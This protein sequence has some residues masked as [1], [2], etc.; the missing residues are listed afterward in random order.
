MSFIKMV[1]LVDSKQQLM[2]IERDA[3]NVTKSDLQAIVASSGHDMKS[4]ITSLLLAIESVVSTLQDDLASQSQSNNET[5]SRRQALGTCVDAFGTIMHLNMIV[6]RSVDYCKILANLSLTPSP[7][8][9]HVKDCIEQVINA[10]AA[11]AGMAVILTTVAPDVPTYLLTDA[12]WLQVRDD[13]SDSVHLHTCTCV[14]RSIVVDKSCQQHQVTLN[15][16]N[17]LSS[18]VSFSCCYAI[19]YHAHQ[20]NLLCMVGNACKYSQRQRVDGSDRGIT[21][22][23][24][25]VLVGGRKLVEFSV[26]DA[27]PHR[28]TPV[29]LQALYNRPVTFKREI[30]G[31]MG[32]GM[33]CLAARVQALGG[34]C[35]ARLRTDGAAGTVVWFR[36]PWKEGRGGEG[37]NASASGFVSTAGQRGSLGAAVGPVVLLMSRF[38]SV[39][40]LIRRVSSGHV[41]GEGRGDAP[42]RR[43]RRGVGKVEGERGEVD[44]MQREGGRE[45]GTGRGREKSERGRGRDREREKDESGDRA[46]GK[47]EDE[48]RPATTP[49]PALLPAPTSDRPLP[50]S[51]TPNAS[52][53]APA[54]GSTP[55]SLPSTARAPLAVSTLDLVPEHGPLHRLDIPSFSAQ[56]SVVQF[57]P[58]HTHQPL[59]GLTILVVD[60]APTI[61]KMVVRMLT[62]AG[63]TVD[64]AKDGR[65][66]LEVF[67]AAQ[68][69]FDMVVTDI[70]VP[71][72]GHACAYVYTSC[73]DARTYAHMYDIC[74]VL[75]PPSHFICL[76]LIAPFPF[77][78]S[79]FPSL[80]LSSS[81]ST[82][83]CL[84]WT[85]GGC[86]RPSA[87]WN[88]RAPMRPTATS[89]GPVP[90]LI[91]PLPRAAAL[92]RALALALAAVRVPA[93][94]P[95]AVW[96]S[97]RL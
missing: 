38:G 44:D 30:V 8:S 19:C 72:S 52:I 50:V 14:L 65:E 1:L 36:V 22:T 64:F 45:R 24:F 47:G 29:E 60:D 5:S 28:F 27:S 31:G 54:P 79:T 57:A 69:A 91:L 53:R 81:P 86:V 46:E 3:A 15:H 43:A 35:G 33:C 76:R 40:K 92:A 41:R 10:S 55:G 6:N 16:L 84:A 89:T 87:R 63:A 97:G 62:A 93:P 85:G 96:A 37:A 7:R 77:L 59:Q 82:S 39:S 51:L 42:Q 67:K 11:D 48:E 18:F 83:R 71:A 78:L 94:G 74:C 49:V 32:T 75:L 34:D 2:K 13:L 56:P 61:V 26:Q 95:R 68:P 80:S 4:P 73:T 21:V 12:F 58:V 23:A 66:G 17:L 25:C 9:V 20:D 88:H 70:Q 90:V